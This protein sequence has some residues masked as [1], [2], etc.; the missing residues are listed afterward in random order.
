MYHLMKGN[1]MTTVNPRLNV[2]L[3]SEVA[4][5]LSKKAKQENVSL[6]K[7]A[8]DLIEAAMERDEDIYFSKI[9]EKRAASGEKKT[10]HADID[11]D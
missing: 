10:K 1:E 6:S 4:R 5:V 7:I 11:W 3:S 2:T 9:A 8:K